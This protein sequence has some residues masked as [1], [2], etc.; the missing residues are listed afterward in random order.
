MPW[1]IVPESEASTGVV[2]TRRISLR[3]LAARLGT[4]EQLLS[5]YLKTQD[6]WEAKREAAKCQASG[7]DRGLLHSMVRA[8]LCEQVRKI[9]RRINAGTPN[10]SDAERRLN[11]SLKRARAACKAKGVEWTP[12]AEKRHIAWW[13]KIEARCRREGRK[14]DIRSLQQFAEHGIPRAREV[15]AKVS[16]GQNTEENLS[17]ASRAARKSFGSH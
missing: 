10:E 2:T 3:M 8:A 4:S 6:W 17:S 14:A 1:E 11:R 7:D 15:L 16:A 13:W 9:E 5:H 12:G